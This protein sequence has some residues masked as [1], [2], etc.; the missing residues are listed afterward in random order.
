MLSHSEYNLPLNRESFD[1]L[2]KKCD[3]IIISKNRYKIPLGG[4]LM[5]ELDI[6]CGNLS[7]LILVEVEF[8]SVAEA[9]AFIPPHWFGDDVTNDEHYHNSYISQHGIKA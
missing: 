6:F 3:G 8:S 2:I 7:G 1:R 4:G 9:N 5:A